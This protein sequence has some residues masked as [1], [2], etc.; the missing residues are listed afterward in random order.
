MRMVTLL[1]IAAAASAVRA[2]DTSGHVY[3]GLITDIF[4]T[5]MLKS[6]ASQ[7]TLDANRDRYHKLYVGDHLSCAQNSSLIMELA[8]EPSKP[9]EPSKRA[10]K[11]PGGGR[12][13]LEPGEEMDVKRPDLPRGDGMGP[14]VSSFNR[15][16][17]SRAIPS[18]IYSPAQGE[19]VDPDAL[20]IEWT[21]LE[22]GTKVSLYI[23]T[24][25]GTEIWKE[26]G[27]D[28][29]AG[30]LEPAEARRHLRDYRRERGVGPLTLYAADTAAHRSQSTFYLLSEEQQKSLDQQLSLCNKN[31][32]I[33]MHLCRISLLE[34]MG[35][36]NRVAGEY[37]QSLELA[38]ESEE[39]LENTLSSCL[40][41]GD[42]ACA[43][44]MKSRLAHH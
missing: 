30:R 13:T 10:T 23:Q 3:V 44:Q 14:A 7:R 32:G 17:A 43:Q 20:T 9:G 27:I 2:D 8:G 25:E 37:R 18:I 40:V 41:I 31:T 35:M 12:A 36:L 15:A 24:P 21:P 22:E 26:Y 42:Q 5:C 16:G 39:L 4:G 33:L 34:D 1:L 28:G 11:K 19:T 38:P 29:K 6:G